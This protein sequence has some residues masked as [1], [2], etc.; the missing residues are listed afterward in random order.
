MIWRNCFASTEENEQC[1][2]TFVAPKV[3][4]QLCELEI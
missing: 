3:A 2:A 4:G 1:N